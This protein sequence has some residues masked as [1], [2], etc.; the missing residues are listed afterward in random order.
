MA[1]LIKREFSVTY[2]R[3]YICTL[4]K[5]LGYSFQKA[6]FV[7][8]HLDED[9]RQA[10]LQEV[11]PQLLQQAQQKKALIFF[12]DEA[13]FAQWGSLILRAVTFDAFQYSA[14]DSFRLIV[15][16]FLTLLE[17]SQNRHFS[18]RAV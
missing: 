4:W 7:S 17:Q 3:F 8:D 13:S 16:G 14:K 2:N 15:G 10:W 11:W 12:E 5:N 1:Q 6:R 9:R 18:P